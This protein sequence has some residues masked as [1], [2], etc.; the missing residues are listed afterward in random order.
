[1]GDSNKAKLQA[2]VEEINTV[3]LAADSSK[4]IMILHS[5]KN[6]GGTRTC[7][8]NKVICMLSLGP[9]A[10]SVL[11]DLNMAFVDLH[12]VVLSV[13]DLAG[14]DSAKE[15]ANI[16]AP[17]ENSLVGFEGSAIFIPN[18][19]LQNTILTSI[20]KN[21]FELTPIILNEARSFDMEHEYQATAVTHADDLNARLLA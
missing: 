11:L 9:Q 15:V 3:I 8:Q 20:I 4:N 17:E 12:I 14:C 19:V 5:P 2:L 7:L 1:L 13:Q 10:I 16:P 6:F 21:P 18:L